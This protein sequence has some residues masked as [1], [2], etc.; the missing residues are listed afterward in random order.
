MRILP[1]FSTII[2]LT[3]LSCEELPPEVTPCQTTRVVLV[4]EFTGIDCVNCPIG[5]DKLQ[6]IDYQNPGKIVIVGIHA[7]FFA[8]DHDGFDLKC[9]DG[10]NLESFLG[11]VQ[12]YPSASINRTIFEGEN[13]LPL[14][15]PQWAGLIN[16]EICKRPIAELSLSTNYSSADSMV[17]VTVDVQAASYFADILDYDLGL[18]ILITESD[19]V[20]YQKTPTGVDSFYVHKHVLRDVLSSDF[21]GDLIVPKGQ[22]IN[23]RSVT[24]SDYKIPAEWNPQKCYALAFI[25]YKGYRLDVLQAIEKKLVD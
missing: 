25:H 5:A 24:I 1:L 12:G 13:Q 16:S 18:T 9:T 22:L 15:L 11:P 6:Q 17:S 8:T 4:E 10:E 23:S 19:I 20:G 14:S 3:L 2:L 7:G 21:R